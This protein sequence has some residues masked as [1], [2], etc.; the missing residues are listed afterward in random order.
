[1]VYDGQE[2]E[3]ADESRLVGVKPEDSFAHPIWVEQEAEER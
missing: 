3:A 2:V 1:M